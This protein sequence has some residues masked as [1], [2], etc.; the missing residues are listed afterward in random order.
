MRTQK[1]IVMVYNYDTA[2]HSFTAPALGPNQI[3]AP[4]IKNGVP[5]VTTFSFTVRKPSSYHW[6]CMMPCDDAKGWATRHKHNI[7]G[8]V[9][10]VRAWTGRARAGRPARCAHHLGA[11]ERRHDHGVLERQRATVGQPQLTDH[12][13]Y[14][15]SPMTGHNDHGRLA[16]HPAPTTGCRAP[17]EA[18]HG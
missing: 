16:Q 18:R 9:T 14:R 6:L 17:R 15:R 13:P 11:P 10:I 12:W 1:V 7:A 2:R 3:M 8:T 5:T 4:S